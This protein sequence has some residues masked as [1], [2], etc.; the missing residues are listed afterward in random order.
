MKK[1]KDFFKASFDFLHNL[2]DSE[3]REKLELL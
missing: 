2:D 1:Y 3:L